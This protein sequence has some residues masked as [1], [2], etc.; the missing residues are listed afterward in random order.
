MA[1]GHCAGEGRLSLDRGVLHQDESA[2]VAL[3]IR[4][5]EEFVYV[6]VDVAPDH[7]RLL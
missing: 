1:R 3:A 7:R 5:G 6:R 2:P 4:R